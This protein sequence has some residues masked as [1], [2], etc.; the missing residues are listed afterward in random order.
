LQLA[1]AQRLGAAQ[2]NLSSVPSRTVQVL[3]S[4]YGPCLDKPICI[5]LHAYYRPG[6]SLILLLLLL[7]LLLKLIA[8]HTTNSPQYNNHGDPSALRMFVHCQ[9]NSVFGVIVGSIHSIAWCRL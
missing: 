7:L 3:G 8:K 9:C 5:H 4:T 2:I 1:W 6:L